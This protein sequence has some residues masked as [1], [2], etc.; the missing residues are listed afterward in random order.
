M[1]LLHENLGLIQ[2]QSGEPAFT[3]NEETPMAGLPETRTPAEQS[4]ALTNQ[5]ID[6]TALAQKV[7]AL[8]KKEAKLESERQ[9]SQILI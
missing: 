9:G 3:L 1:S 8:L 4:P 6:L 5:T 2:T 7:Y